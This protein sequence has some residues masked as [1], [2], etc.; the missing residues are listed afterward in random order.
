MITMPPLLGETMTVAALLSEALESPENSHTALRRRLAE[1]VLRLVDHV[2]LAMA[3]FDRLEHLHTADAELRTLRAHLLLALELGL[4]EE[5][6]FLH[7]VDR[8]DSMG[9][10]LG[11]WI[12]KQTRTTE[13]S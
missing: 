1:G 12:K 11:G 4:L 8:I 7:L 6:L 10:Q 13:K 3:D 2:V 9:R 5:P